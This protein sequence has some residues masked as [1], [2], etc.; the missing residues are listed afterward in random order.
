[1][2]VEA[3]DPPTSPWANVAVQ[4]AVVVALMATI[5][6]TLSPTS[7]VNGNVWLKLLYLSRAALL[8]G[9]ATWF[10]HMR[11]LGWNDM[12]LVRPRWVRFAIAMPVGLIGIIIAVNGLRAVLR[13]FGV[14][15]PDYSMFRSL[16]GNLG[17]Y[18]FWLVPVTWGSAAF[19]EELI[20]RGFILD[21]L[22][23]LIRAE[24]GP[25][26]LLAIMLQAALFG[27]LHFY[28]GAGGAAVAG[29]VG[30]GFGFV[31]LF[32]GRNPWACIVLHGLFDS[33]AMTGFYF[34]L[35]NGA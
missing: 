34:G 15:G 16:H 8:L 12:G 18:L 17:L 11:G 22:R 31:W 1:M 35:T 5:I 20:C 29:A 4:L 30:L 27:A 13:H 10:L 32:C 2:T 6:P 14:P 24:R 21:A 19:G 28:Q 23:R 3:A 33:I 7:A 25:M 9:V 26:E